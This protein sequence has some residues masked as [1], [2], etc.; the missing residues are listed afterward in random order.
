MKQHY[1]RIA[2]KTLA[3]VS[4]SILPNEEIKSSAP[5]VS[6]I[7][8]TAFR[9]GSP[10]GVLVLT[11]RRLIFADTIYSGEGSRAEWPLS[12]INS[13]TLRRKAIIDHFEV[14][15]GGETF[16]FLMNKSD[17]KPFVPQV[18]QA[19][20]DSTL[21]SQESGQAGAPDLGESLAKVSELF[22]KGL[23]SHGEFVDAKKKILGQ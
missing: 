15:S 19:L 5:C 23:L 17:S 20:A 16:L 3:L 4:A 18:N 10:R 8:T 12:R 1:E 9:G 21:V 14:N 6:D 2:A 13:V 11:N 7:G 22:E